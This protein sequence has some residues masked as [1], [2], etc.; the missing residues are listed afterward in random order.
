M[1]CQTSPQHFAHYLNQKVE[2]KVSIK[3]KTS[4]NVSKKLMKISLTVPKTASKFHRKRRNGRQYPKI[5]DFQSQRSEN[6][7]STTQTSVFLE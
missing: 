7:N 2:K 6:P 5:P 4:S 1:R 3:A